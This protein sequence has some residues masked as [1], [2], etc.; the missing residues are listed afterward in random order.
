MKHKTGLVVRD[1]IEEYAKLVHPIK[2]HPTKLI[3]FVS[4]TDG[5]TYNVA[6]GNLRAWLREYAR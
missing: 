4:L 2:M 5:K 1:P 3:W 6:V